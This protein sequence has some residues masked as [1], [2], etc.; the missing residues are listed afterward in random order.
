MF[1]IRAEWEQ[2]QQPELQQR[3]RKKFSYLTIGVKINKGG[4]L[5]Q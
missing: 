3:R 5:N 2:Q 4:L 1:I